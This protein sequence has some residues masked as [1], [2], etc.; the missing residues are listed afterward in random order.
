MSST[1]EKDLKIESSIL[2]GHILPKMLAF[3]LPL[4][5]SGI[6]QQLYNTADTLIVGAM[7]GKEALAAVG[8]TGSTSNLLVTIFLSIFVG[9][10]ILVARAKGTGDDVSLKKIVSTTYVTAL[11]FGVI[12]TIAGELLARPMMLLTECPPNIIDDAT[13]YLQIYFLSM[14]GSMFANFSSSVIRSSGDSRS[15]FIYLSISGLCNVTGNVV[16]VL[17]VNNPVIAVAISTTVSIYVSALLFFIHMVRDKSA[18]GLSPFNFSFNVPI[19]MKTARFGIPSAIASTT[20]A[21]TNLIIQPVVNSYGDIAISG[22]A[23]SVAIEGYVFIIAQAFGTTVSTFMGQN[24]GASKR[25]RVKRVL[26]SGYIANSL[27]AIVFS[28]IIL[29]IGKTLI[30]LFIPGETEAIEFGYLRLT[31]IIGAGVL[32]AIL[33]INRGALQAY[34]YTFLQMISNLIGISLFSIVW[35]LVIYPLDPT[36]FNFLISY[37]ISWL[38]SALPMLIVVILLTKRYLNGKEFKL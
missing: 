19:F 11:A 7:G 32:N 15:P 27:I 34:G 2:N 35:V 3:A 6:L 25:D 21:L 33:N 9:T 38:V 12:L 14:P 4:I 31:M 36:P 30:G 1:D 16:L 8:A 23:A 5:L 26:V 29:S 28:V 37:P 20:Y 24:I 18:T 10:D 13:L 17:T 22:T